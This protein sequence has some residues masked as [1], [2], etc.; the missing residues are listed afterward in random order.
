LEDNIAD[1]L[2]PQ[3]FVYYIIDL[4]ESEHYCWVSIFSILEAK[5]EALDDYRDN[6][7]HSGI[8]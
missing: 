8:I 1:P 6:R 3:H 5:Q 7:L 2:T 4:S